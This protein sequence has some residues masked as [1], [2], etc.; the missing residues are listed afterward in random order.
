MT[1]YEAV[2]RDKEAGMTAGEI[3]AKYDISKATVWDYARKW[4]KEQMAESERKYEFLNANYIRGA[5]DMANKIDRLKARMKEG[6]Y[7]GFD[8]S[9]EDLRENQEAEFMF[10][11]CKHVYPNLVAFQRPDGKLCTMTWFEIAKSAM[12]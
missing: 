1:K 9:P 7:Y 5:W 2:G 4:R 3:A 11:K 6:E 12:M 8:I 10:L